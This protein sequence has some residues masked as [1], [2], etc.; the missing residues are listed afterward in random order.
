MGHLASNPATEMYRVGDQWP[1]LYL[2]PIKVGVKLEARNDKGQKVLKQISNYK[3]ISKWV[4][5]L[6]TDFQSCLREGDIELVPTPDSFEGYAEGEGEEGQEV[7]HELPDTHG[8][9]TES[10]GSSVA[11]KR[12]H[13]EVED[14]PGPKVSQHPLWRWAMRGKSIDYLQ[15][16]EQATKR[17]KA[18]QPA[19]QA[20]GPRTRGF[21]AINQVS[22]EIPVAPKWRTVAERK[23]KSGVGLAHESGTGHIEQGL[24]EGPMGLEQGRFSS[25]SL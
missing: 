17:A 20:L 11:L 2:F 21:T 16:P 7:G 6:H 3:K 5:G 12:V 25:T 8:P 4:N 22:V 23:K 19:A 10:V 1:R 9:Y 14:S 18:A 24:E 15:K 13:S